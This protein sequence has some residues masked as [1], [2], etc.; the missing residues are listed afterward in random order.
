MRRIAP[1][2]LLLIF[3]SACIL[4]PRRQGPPDQPWVANATLTELQRFT[5]RDLG[6]AQGVTLLDDKLYIYGDVRSVKPRCGIIKEYTLDLKP[7]SRWV[8]LKR[9]GKPLLLHPTGLTR[10]PVLGVFLGDTI[11]QK[12]RIYLLDWDQAWKDGN[13]DHAVRAEVADDLAVSGCRPCLVAVDGR[14]LLATADYNGGSRSEVRL[15]DPNRLL[16]AKKSSSPGVLLHRFACPN[17]VQNLDWN[18]PRGQLTLILNHIEGRG[19]QLD[20]VDLQRAITSGRTDAPDVLCKR[21]IFRP[22]DE[23]EGYTPVPKNRA[24]FVTSSS[25]DNLTLGRITELRPT[26]SAAES[27][28][29]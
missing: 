3:L 27:M 8:W 13:L 16:E 2:A 14:I 9:A 17:W 1:Y 12:G 23:L 20:E 7:T 6:D 21:L 10:H 15:Y 22:H 5:D 18:Q 28:L 24:L 4:L 26:A 19:W 29:P 11:N 25:R